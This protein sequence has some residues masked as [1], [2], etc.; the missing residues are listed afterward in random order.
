MLKRG[1]SGRIQGRKNDGDGAF[2][3]GVVDP[4]VLIAAPFRDGLRKDTFE[5]EARLVSVRPSET[6]F[7]RVKRAVGER[8]RRSQSWPPRGRAVR[9]AISSVETSKKTTRGGGQFS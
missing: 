5:K 2:R 1:G 6:G 3:L 8:P 7:I 4:F 9:G